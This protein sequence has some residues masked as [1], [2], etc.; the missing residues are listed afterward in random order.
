MLSS[1]VEVDKADTGPIH[2]S[3]SANDSQS[4]TP[5]T[6]NPFMM[7]NDDIPIYFDED[8]DTGIG[9][10]LWS[11]GLAIGKYISQHSH[12]V[13]NNLLDMLHRKN[14]SS[15]ATTTTI[16]EEEQPPPNQ[17]K[18]LSLLELGSGN[19][20]LSVCFL[21]VAKDLLEHVA[22]TDTME[23]LPLIETTIQANRHILCDDVDNGVFVENDHGKKVVEISEHLWGEFSDDVVQQQ[24]PKEQRQE[25]QKDVGDKGGD[26]GNIRTYPTL[27]HNI[28]FDIIVGSDVAYRDELHDPLIASL[29][30][31][32]HSSSQGNSGNSTIIIIGVTMADTKPIF[33][34]KLTQAGFMYERLADHLLDIQF[35]GS[36]TFGVFICTRK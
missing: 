28:K 21:A 31:Y 30:H 8:W 5:A 14:N 10:G 6:R 13:R 27:D 1:E 3:T 35:R 7:V 17:R 19:G 12:H 16:D 26:N 33:F 20:F 24:Q 22:I 36:T 9:G 32:S 18:R 15:P 23:H 2:T 11:T 34:H 4:N 25:A 29:L